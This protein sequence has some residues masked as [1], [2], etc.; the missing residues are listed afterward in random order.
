[1]ATGLNYQG[2]DGEL[3]LIDK[4]QSGAG[5]AGTP[6]GI[7]VFFEQMDMRLNYQPRPEELPRLDRERATTDWH[8]QIGSE[9]PLLAATECTFGMVM[10][11]GEKDAVLQFVGVDWSSQEG[12]STSN[13]AWTVH[14]TP[15][16]GLVTTK[17]RGLTGDG[18][19]RGGRIDSKGSAIQMLAFA[20]KKKVAVDIETIW[21]ERDGANKF[22]LRLKEV[23]FEPGRQQVGESADFVTIS[24]TGM[25]YGEVQRITAFSR[26]TS[27][28]TSL[29]L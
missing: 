23:C 14:G 11:S 19:Y 6:Y 28:L 18:L 1:M 3:H 9:E 10:S 26:A 29:L 21:M 5:A 16:A 24:F 4:S 27:V 17:G 15:T 8:L 12:S 13:P 20:D 2:R 22:G 25:V 7:K